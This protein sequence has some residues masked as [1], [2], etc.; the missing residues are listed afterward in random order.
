MPALL[1]PDAVLARSDRLSWRVLDDEAL[2]LFPEVG[3]LHRLNPTGTRMW[4]LLDGSR[5][6]ELIA[7]A[8]I[9]EYD[10]SVGEALGQ[11][12]GLANELIAARLV[13]VKGEP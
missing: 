5:S 7:S 1:S 2:I 12:V 6:L 8:L 9:E 11:L 13:E 3:T 4:E 10:V